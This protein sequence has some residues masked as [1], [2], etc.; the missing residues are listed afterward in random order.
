[1][2]SP[3]SARSK[4]PLLRRF[5]RL[6]ANQRGSV[7]IIAA[8]ALPALLGFGGLGVD[9]SIWLRAKN[10]VQG[11]ADAGAMSAAAAAAAAGGWSSG[12]PAT[13]ALAA[14]AVNGYQNGVNGVVVTFNH[15]PI[16]GTQAGNTSAAEI[17]VSAPQ[18]FYLASYF[19]TA[20]GVSAPT[21]SG[22]AVVVTQTNPT[23][24]LALNKLD[25]TSGTLTTSGGANLT[26]T[27]CYVS[28]DSPDAKSI[29]TAGGGSITAG[30]VS[31]VGDVSGNVTA[32][33]GPIQTQSN[34]IPDPY[35][36]TRS[37][38][39]APPY[40]PSS[41][42]NW[43]GNITNPTGVKAFQGDVKVN[44]TTTLQPGVYII[45]GTFSSSKA[46]SG[47]G[48]TIVVRNSS[49]SNSVPF[50][51]AGSGTLTL[52]APTTGSTA[53]IAVWVAT[54]CAVAPCHSDN[55]TGNSTPNI[56]GAIYA[57]NDQ[58][59]FSGTSTSSTSKCLQ[60]V[61]SQIVVTGTPVFK[62][63]CDGVGISDP[64]AKWALVE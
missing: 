7:G 42:N 34:P 27:N 14:A 3:E 38:P 60:M 22:R 20:F 30:W 4:T 63:D 17:I 29:N 54:S 2:I 48:V 11:A 45:D 32:T 41:D 64:I 39:A 50:S 28:D 21:V 57:P 8:V 56:T 53:G 6:S 47:T 18:Q 13:E 59:K 36:V 31:T 24:I 12:G 19:A 61:A 52:T 58:V 10:G 37:I 5:R 62:H 25:V 23:C 43:S 49:G 55:L 1:M 16:S 35:A 44:G 26:A 40:Q 46:L 15:P 33:N 51:L 9:V